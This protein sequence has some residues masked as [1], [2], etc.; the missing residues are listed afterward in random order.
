[1]DKTQYEFAR[2]KNGSFSSQLANNSFINEWV[3]DQPSNPLKHMFN[4]FIKRINLP[5]H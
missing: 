2:L 5:T 3:S 1:M 4:P